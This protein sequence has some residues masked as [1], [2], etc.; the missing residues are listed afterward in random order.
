[1]TTS[2]APGFERDILDQPDAL[3]RCAGLPLP[4]AIAALDFARFDRIILTGMGSSDYVTIPLELALARLGLP[5]WRL[6]TG[7]LLET[8]QLIRPGTLLWITSQ[9]GRS[10]EVVA[11]LERLPAGHGAT[12]VATTN[13]PASPLAR[14]AD[15]L[16]ELHAGAE[17]T[18]S[19][20]SYLNSLA[21]LHRVGAPLRGEAD[22]Q[23][24]ETIRAVAASL[25]S[26]VQ[27]PN[28]AV[29]ALAERILAFPNPRLALVGT[30]EDAATALTG[31]LI[32]KEASKVSAEGYVGGEF[33]HGPMEL[34][35]P[36]LAVLLL[37]SAE[38]ANPTLDRLA[39]DLSRSG[40]IVMGIGP[41]A[42]E[43]AE[44]IALPGASNFARLAH[45]MAVLQQL[46]VCL[47]RGSGLVP[48]EFRFGQKI[49]AL[50]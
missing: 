9:S 23:A 38:A 7:R 10:G 34:A 5:V 11:L 26:V 20:K 40:S 42:Y 36:G 12:V 31:A 3:E 6:Q 46:S 37:G 32:L 47:A 27:T 43:G 24:V 19:S 49:T 29:Q 35:G 1:M 4:P 2:I 25:R 21:W 14:G 13:D 17:A 28:P 33:R 41:H 8:P 50:L 22:H 44:P 18:V 15:H 39:R 45:A 16:I 30:G 48:G